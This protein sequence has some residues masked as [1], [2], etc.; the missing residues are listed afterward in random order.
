MIQRKVVVK[1]RDQTEVGHSTWAVLSEDADFRQLLEAGILSATLL[2]TGLTR[3]RASCYVGRTTCSD[4]D[5][6]I[7]DKVPGALKALLSYATNS[8]FRIENI[9]SRTSDLGRLFSLLVQQFLSAVTQYVSQSRQFVYAYNNQVGALAGGRIDIPKSIQLRA[10]GMVHR[11]AFSKAYVTFNT[12]L[13][14]I[15]LAAL[16]EVG[17]ICHLVGIEPDDA[18]RARGIA[19][20]FSDCRDTQVL[21]GDR[22]DLVRLASNL[23]TSN[24]TVQQRDIAALASVILAHEGFEGLTDSGLLVPRSWFLNLEQLFEQAVISLLR[25]VVPPGTFVSHGRM[26]PQPIFERETLVYQAHPD[27]VLVHESGRVTVGDVKY[28][29]WLGTA[30]ASDLYQLLVHTSAFSG[31]T[32]FLVFPHDEYQARSLGEAVTGPDAWLFALDVSN[33]TDSVARMAGDLGGGMSA[34]PLRR[35]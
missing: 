3:L 6:E 24:L 29:N 31:S 18:A 23:T 1:E 34:Y 19:L 17:R 26:N 2:P 11:L 25:E 30:V 14:R 21:V 33:L 5:V 20:L 28:K 7:Q 35:P 16:I 27:I 4:I 12:P 15:I 13:N 10:R 8:A 22:A 9:D 32:S